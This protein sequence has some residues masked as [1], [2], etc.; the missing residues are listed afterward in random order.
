[1]TSTLSTI[2][3][4]RTASIPMS[5]IATTC[6][7]HAAV[8]SMQH[9]FVHARTTLHLHVHNIHAHVIHQHCGPAFA[10][11]I[12]MSPSTTTIQ[13]QAAS[14]HHLICTATLQLGAACPCCMNITTQPLRTMCPCHQSTPPCSCARHTDVANHHHLTA[15]HIMPA[16]STNTNLQLHTTC[17]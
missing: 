16:S 6:M 17:L 2:L 10:C 5:H 15:L 7:H 4:L 3:Q 12:L 13:L 1:M 9:A 14:T 8:D 11:N